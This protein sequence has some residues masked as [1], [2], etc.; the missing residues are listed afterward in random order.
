MRDILAVDVSQRALAELEARLADPASGAPYTPSILGNDLCVRAWVGDVAALPA[1]QGPFDV[2]FFNAVWGN[3][4]DPRRA[5]LA[6]AMLL[7]PGGSAVISHPLGRAWHANFRAA[8][9]QVCAMRA[10]K[11]GEPHLCMP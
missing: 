1:W 2:T 7:R 9:P 6:V 8:N 11:M 5:L 3:L 4:H 10:R